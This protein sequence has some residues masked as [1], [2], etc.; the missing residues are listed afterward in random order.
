M[1]TFKDIVGY[2]DLY[3]IS[4]EGNVKSLA[5]DKLKKEKFLKP[6]IHRKGYLFVIL[7]KDGKIEAKYIH[8]LVAQAFIPNPENLPQVNHKDENKTNNFVYLNEDGTVDLEK[9]NL[10]WCDRSYN[11]NYGTRNQRIAETMRKRR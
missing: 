8:R 1:K 5:N 6:K 11:C 4:N 2:E 7:H 9:S 3:Q 10:E